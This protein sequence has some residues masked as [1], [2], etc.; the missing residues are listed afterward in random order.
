MN[1]ANLYNT[2]LEKASQV[3][4]RK[5]KSNYFER[6]HIV[7]KSIGG[8]N[9]K[10][11]LILLT[12]KEHFVCHHLLTKIYPSPELKFAFW[13]MCNQ[14]SGDVSRPY[15]V[16]ATVYARAKQAFAKANSTRHKGKTISQKQKETMRRNMLG[17][18]I[19]KSGAES[20]LYGIA[21]TA[22]TVSKIS[23]TKID[24]PE[25]NA[26]FKGYYQTPKGTFASIRH[27]SE[28][29]SIAKNQIPRRCN[30]PDTVITA[31]HIAWNNDLNSSHLGKTFRELGWDFLP[32]LAECLSSQPQ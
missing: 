13:A 12:A 18:T 16:T 25:R 5:T 7:P 21:R 15:R 14:I 1:Y 19:H 20:H 32:V 24:H 23:Q 8:S 27:A 10:Q 2:I 3:K 30:Q 6:H 4:R 29:N 31:R 17:N 11:N 26:S 22:E 28:A 9:D